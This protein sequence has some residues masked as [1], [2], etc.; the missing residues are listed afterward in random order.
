MQTIF[1]GISH[2]SG[3]LERIHCGK[4]FLVV[5][6]SYPFLNIK[7]SV[8]ALPVT[9]KVMFSGFTPNP[10]YEQV[11]E[12][13]ELFKSTSCEAILAVGGGSAIDVAKCIKLAVLAEE[14]DKALIPPLVSQLLP[15]EGS[16]IPF[17][18]IPTTAG[19]SRESTH[20]A[21]MYFEGT[22]SHQLYLRR[23][24]QCV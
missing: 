24:R 8:D 6:S 5:D 7:E 22:L 3:I 17:M 13:V 2:L 1:N 15:I 19:T 20:N 23:N 4:L 9:G 10:L 11:F 21:V 18:A 16:R 14:G 12:G